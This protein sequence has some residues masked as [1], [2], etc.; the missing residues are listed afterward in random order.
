MLIKKADDSNASSI[1][2]SLLGYRADS[3]LKGL[4]I[5]VK[6]KKTKTQTILFHGRKHELVSAELYLKVEQLSRS[7][8]RRVGKEC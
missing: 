7:E 6:S 1:E 4:S 2:N 5:K 8:E 3:K